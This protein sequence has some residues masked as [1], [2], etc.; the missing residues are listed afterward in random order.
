MTDFDKAVLKWK[1]EVELGT[2]HTHTCID[3]PLLPCDACDEARILAGEK[4]E[5]P[6]KRKP[7][8]AIKEG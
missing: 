6:E 4:L 7:P 5:R 1:K 3:R 8:R 2:A